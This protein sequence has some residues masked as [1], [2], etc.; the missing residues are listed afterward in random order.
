MYTFINCRFV[1]GVGQLVLY[2]NEM[3][4]KYIVSTFQNDS[5]TSVDRIF[6]TRSSAV[7]YRENVRK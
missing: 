2:K 4:G 7:Q 5:K 6:D 1:V 3:T